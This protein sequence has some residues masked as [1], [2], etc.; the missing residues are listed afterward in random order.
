MVAQR[1]IGDLM[2][3][4]IFL[5]N[6]VMWYRRPFLKKI[7][8]IYDIQFIFTD[9]QVSKNVY[10]IE[11]SDNID[12]LEGLKYKIYRKPFTGISISA[13]RELLI[14]DCDVIVDSLESIQAL[15]SF[16]IAKIRRK[17]IVFWSEE[18]DWK[19]KDFFNTK[20]KSALKRL[21]VSNS[22]ALIVPGT[23]HQSYFISLG[24]RLDNIFIVPNVSNISVKKSDYK[25]KDRLIKD[26]GIKNKKVILYVG[27]LVKRKGVDYL[28]K[29]FAKLRKEKDDVMLI[30]IGRGECKKELELLSKNLNVDNDIHFMGYVEDDLLPAYYLLSNICVIPS[31]TD[32]IGDPWVFIVNEAMYFGK[33][34]IATDAVGAAFDM[35]KNGENGF[36]VPEKD[37]DA[38]YSSMKN[39]LIDDV[40][41]KK[42]GLESR[43]IIE[44][45]YRYENMVE[46]FKEAIEWALK[47]KKS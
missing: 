28:I 15:V 27:R 42:M 7:D 2:T 8:T 46:G 5:H 32:G 21:I 10:G 1:F 22:D 26:F 39:I 44:E 17:P 23:K 34:I 4:I 3:K 30:I 38:L 31:I 37:A 33:P 24:A 36:I 18:W 41:E 9:L 47:K 25:N 20:I 13:I 40:V 29:A 16:L 14:N 43:K 12:G 6:T 45:K 11:I 19:D 35:I